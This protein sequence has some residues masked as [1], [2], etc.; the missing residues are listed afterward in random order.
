MMIPVEPA[1]RLATIQTEEHGTV[2]YWV[3][4]EEVYRLGD[5]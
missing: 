3:H 2:S 4:N 1:K 5:L